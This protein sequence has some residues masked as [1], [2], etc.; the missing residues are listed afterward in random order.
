MP[1]PA[2]S[3]NS[4]HRG[5]EK[6]F[7]PARGDQL[8]DTVWSHAASRSFQSHAPVAMGIQATAA[9]RLPAASSE[10]RERSHEPPSARAPKNQAPRAWPAAI[11]IIF[12]NLT[13]TQIGVEA[14]GL[15]IPQYAHAHFGYATMASVSSASAI[16]LGLGSLLGG[17][18]SDKLGATRT[19][20][21]AL[22]LRAGMIGAL[23]V[24]HTLGLMT[25]PL[26]VGIFAADY[27]LHYAGFVALDSIAPA[28]LGDNAVRLNR[29]GFYR[30]GII[31]VVGFGAPLAA[32]LVIA[33]LG[34]GAVFW[35]YRSLFLSLPREAWPFFTERARTEN[36]QEPSRL[37]SPQPAGARR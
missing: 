18:V 23:A 37:R 26:L 19:C 22:I 34:Y 24:L 35:A 12:A 9:A 3:Q 1:S 33:A 11:W 16:A 13:L 7:A 15:A 32:G 28:R 6:R 10:Q 17:Q 29:F 5:T 25:A 27:E 21:F 20:V 30:Q 31:N 4:S 14:L 36:A 2:P 8:D